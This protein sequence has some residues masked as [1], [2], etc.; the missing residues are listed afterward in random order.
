MKYLTAFLALAIV[1][2]VGLACSDNDGGTTKTTNTNET[3]TNKGETKPDAA[4]GVT[5][6]SVTLTNPDDETVTDFKTTDKTQNFA[7][8]LSEFE[9]GTKVKGVFTAVNAGGEKNQKILEKE[10]ETNMLTN[11]VHLSLSLPNPFP[12]GDYKIDVYINGKLART[13]NYKV[14]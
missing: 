2:T 13:V 8:K 3:T 5:V 11:T 4:G 6:E 14:L 12:K 10:M 1:L 7:I 9:S